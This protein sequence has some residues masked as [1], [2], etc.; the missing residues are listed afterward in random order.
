MSRVCSVRT[1]NPGKILHVRERSLDQRLVPRLL[2]RDRRLERRQQSERDV[3]RLIA[4]RLG[5]RDVVAEGAQGRRPWRR[6]RLLPSHPAGGVD[7]R[8]DARSGGLRIA[9][10]TRYLTREEETVAL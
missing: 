7:P 2:V 8:D 10:D 1:R 4:L 5:V 6:E 3:R 9:L